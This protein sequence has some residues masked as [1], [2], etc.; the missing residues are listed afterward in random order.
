MD[1]AGFLASDPAASTIRRVN[2]LLHRFSAVSM[3]T[4]NPRYIGTL[5]VN[6]LIP[7]IHPITYGARGFQRLP[8]VRRGHTARPLGT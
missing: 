4:L 3:A 7:A 6:M 8:I 2:R 1:C 5:A